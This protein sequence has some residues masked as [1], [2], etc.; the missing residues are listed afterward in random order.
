MT[1][2]T[3]GMT[4]GTGGMTAVTGGTAAG[5]GT[6]VP[7]VLRDG[8]DRTGVGEVA[9]VRSADDAVRGG[10]RRRRRARR[11]T[12]SRTPPARG[13]LVAEQRVHALIEH[14]REPAE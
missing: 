7:L 8:P 1:A 9:R 12:R 4:A 6:G 14:F 3:G 10:G 11:P 2:G 13:A 5:T